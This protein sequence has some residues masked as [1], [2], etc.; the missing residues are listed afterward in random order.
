[1][2][3]TY[4]YYYIIDVSYSGELLSRACVAACCT[5]YPHREMLDET[6]AASACFGHRRASTLV[7]EA[8]PVLC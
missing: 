6:H 1:M 8:Q 2:C 7:L 4:V 3:Y 5:R